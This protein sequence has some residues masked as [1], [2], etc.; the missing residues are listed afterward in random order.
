MVD[1]TI[2]GRYNE[3]RT[4][5]IPV[6][7]RD[8]NTKE[9]YE[10]DMLKIGIVGCTGKL[11]SAIMKTALESE[12]VELSY[13]IARKGNAFVGKKITELIGGKSELTII[14]DIELADGCD[15]P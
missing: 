7:V 11:G 4:I 2:G 8:K 15:L 13:A 1:E 9:G 14:D 6:R 12:E 10:T 3:G 5:Q